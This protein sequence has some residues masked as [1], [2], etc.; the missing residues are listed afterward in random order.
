MPKF[1]RR[2]RD[3]DFL[4]FKYVVRRDKSML[5]AQSSNFR[6]LPTL[7]TGRQV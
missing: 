5:K 7:P 1:H 2:Q 6:H 4:L 3:P